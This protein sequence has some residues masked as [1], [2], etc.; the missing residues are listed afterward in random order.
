MSVRAQA[1]FFSS[2][3]DTRPDKKQTHLSVVCSL[4]QFVL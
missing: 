1:V 3:V 4:I 2:H